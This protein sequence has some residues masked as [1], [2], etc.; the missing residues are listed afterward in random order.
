MTTGGDHPQL[1]PVSGSIVDGTANTISGKADIDSGVH[2]S[3]EISP[4]ERI[5]KSKSKQK[6]MTGEDEQRSKELI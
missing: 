2:R 6:L 3:A 5:V 4:A 1:E